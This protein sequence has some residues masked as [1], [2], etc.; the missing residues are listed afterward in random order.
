[1]RDHG[2]TAVVAVIQGSTLT[3]AHCGDSRAVLVRQGGSERLTQDHKPVRADEKARIEKL[4]GG[5][6]RNG[7]VNGILGVSRAFGNSSLKQWA[8]SE[9]EVT[10]VQLRNGGCVSLLMLVTK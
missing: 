9:P 1:M 10:Q 4:P 3:V 2:S 6:V 7:R 8:T 5:S